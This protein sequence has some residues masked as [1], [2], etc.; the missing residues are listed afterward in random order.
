MG[1][2]TVSRL[3]RAVNDCDYAPEK[4]EWEDFVLE[5]GS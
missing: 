3:L 2:G 1:D 5:L 4:S